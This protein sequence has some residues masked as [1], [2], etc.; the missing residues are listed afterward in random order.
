M[1]QLVLLG[2]RPNCTAQKRMT[3]VSRYSHCLVCWK[4]SWSL[5]AQLLK[6]DSC[7]SLIPT[8]TPWSGTWYLYDSVFSSQPHFIHSHTHKPWFVTWQQSASQQPELS[9]KIL[10]S[11]PQTSYL[12]R[13]VDQEVIQALELVLCNIEKLCSP[14][15]AALFPGGIAAPELLQDSSERQSTWHDLH[16]VEPRH[17]GEC[18]CSI[19]AWNLSR[20]I[21]PSWG[22]ISK[23]CFLG[24]FIIIISSHIVLQWS[25]IGLW[26]KAKITE[27]VSSHNFNNSEHKEMDLCRS[28]RLLVYKKRF[29]RVPARSL[30]ESI[31]WRWGA[32]CQAPSPP[33]VAPTKHHMTCGNS[34]LCGRWLTLLI[35]NVYH[36]PIYIYIYNTLRLP[37][38][39]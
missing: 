9:H 32:C 18:S 23:N 35:Y 24:R 4:W 29:T 26:S 5:W 7:W 12:V 33:P 10:L 25:L 15:W 28:C 31:W 3:A 38:A 34:L 11:M 8:G 37:L 39:G 36:I 16:Q 19:E 21:E 13:L 27:L 22:R 14:S 1:G 20:L 2:G 17:R 30:S 6:W